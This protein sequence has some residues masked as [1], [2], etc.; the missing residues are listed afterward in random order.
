MKAT[1]PVSNREQENKRNDFCCQEQ[2]KMPSLTEYLYQLKFIT[3]C[4]LDAFDSGCAEEYATVARE[5]QDLISGDHVWI[6]ADRTTYSFENTRPDTKTV[7]GNN[8]ESS[9][10]VWSGQF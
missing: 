9:S 2:D 4:Y 7:K 8:L 10:L 1:Q 3:S 5:P 6:H